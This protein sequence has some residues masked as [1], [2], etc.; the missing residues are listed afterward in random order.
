[1]LFRN[2]ASAR[3]TAMPPSE[4][5]RAEWTAPDPP[6]R[7]QV[8]QF[9]FGVQIERRRLSPDAAE[10]ALAYSEEPKAV[11]SAVADSLF[12]S[13]FCTRSARMPDDVLD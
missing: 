1:M 10:N 13:V 8:V 9:C 5:S 11:S 7:Q 2:A 6:I 3:A 12:R 4:M